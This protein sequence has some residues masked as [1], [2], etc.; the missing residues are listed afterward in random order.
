MSEFAPWRAFFTLHRGAEVQRP[1]HWQRCPE[2]IVIANVQRGP[3]SLQA[4]LVVN[5][6]HPYFFDH[7]LDHIPGIFIA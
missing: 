3:Q 5:E 4:Q 6:A 2:N 1:A 7:P